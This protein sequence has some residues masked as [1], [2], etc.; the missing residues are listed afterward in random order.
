MLKMIPLA[1]ACLLLGG[2]PEAKLPKPTPM[3]PA[4]KAVISQAE[5]RLIAQ[6]PDAR[7]GL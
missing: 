5:S 6:P 2:C 1:I 7:P 4:P 3:V